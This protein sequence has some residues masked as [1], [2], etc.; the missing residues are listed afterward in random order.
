MP[1]DLAL[2]DLFRPYLLKGENTAWHAVLSVI[3]VESFETALGPEGIVIR[4]VA[5]FSGDVEITFDPLHGILRADAA[6]TEGHPRSQPGRREPWFDITDTHVEFALSAPR[7][8]GQ[9]VANGVATISGGDAAFAPT[10]AVLDAW[11]AIP[12]DAPPSDYPGTGFSLDLMLAG[13]VMR[14][15]F[16]KPAQMQPD[17]LLV[18]DTSRTD[19]VFTLPRIK[20]RLAQGSDVGANLDVSIA[21]LGAAGIDDPG[22]IAAAELITMTPPY[23]FI[24]DGRV[25]GFGFRS[26]VLDL[27][28]GFTPPAILD[29]FGFDE[30]WTGLYLPEIRLFVAPSGMED[31]AVD[32][33]VRNFLIGLGQSSGITGD[34]ELM[35]INQGSGALGLSARFFDGDGRAI[36]ITRLSDTT[37]EVLLPERSRMVIDI[38][39]GRPAYAA[40]ATFGG[41]PHNGLVHDIDLSAAAELPIGLTATDTSAPQKTAT[42][43]VTARRRPAT[44]SLP[45]PGATP[46]QPATVRTTGITLEGAPQTTPELILVRQDSGSVTISLNPAT[47]GTTWTVAG[48]A[49]PSGASVTFPLAAGQTKPIRAELSSGAVTSIVCYF[50]FDRPDVGASLGF[51]TDPDN[52]N[53]SPAVDPSGSA[54]WTPPAEA[55]LPRYRQVLKRITA[56]SLTLS[57]TASYEGDNAKDKYNYLLSRRRAEALRQ[58]LQAESANPD[59][60]QR[61]PSFTLTTDPPDIGAAAPP[62]SWVSDWKTHAAPRNL[63]WKATIG[64]FGPVSLPGTITDGEA[65]RPAGPPPPPPTIPTQDNPPATPPPPDWFRSVALKVRIVRDQFVAVEL[66][67]S[68]DFETAT[69]QRLRNGGVASGDIPQFQG[70]GS[71]NPT[72]GIVNYKILYQTDP[73]SQTD[74]VKLY[75]GADPN[76]RDGLV[77]TGQLPGQPLQAPST[78]RNVLGMTTVFTP[79][80]AATA[81]ANPADGSIGEIALSAAVLGLPIALAEAGFLNVERVVLYGGELNVTARAGQWVSTLLFDVETAISASISIGGFKILEIPREKPVAIRYKA[82]GLRMGYPPGASSRFELRPMFDSSKGYSI[83]L[84]G[85]GAVRVPDPIG[86]IIQVL[87]ARIARTNPLTFEIDLGFAVDLGVVTIERARVRLPVDPLGPPELTAFAASMNVP[88]VLEGRGYMEI[89]STPSFEIKGQIDVSLVPLKLRLAAGIGVA[90]IPASEGGPATGVIITLE[91]ELPVAI[92]LAQSGFGIYGFLGLFAMHYARDERGITSLTPALTWLKEKAQGNPINIA[93]WTPQVDHWAFGVGAILGTMEGGIIFNVKGMVILELPGPR[94]LLVVRANLLAVL[95]DLK[96]KNAEGTFLCV[97]DLDFGRGTLTIGISIE[98]KITPIVEISIPIEAYFSLGSGGDWHL[99]LG[100]F[101]GTDTLGRP[102]PG[103]IH[104]MILGVFDGSG[105]VMISGHGIPAYQGLSA[106]NGVGLAVGLEVSIVWGNTAVG[107][108]LRATAGFNAVLGFDPFYVGGI[109][110]V[111]GELHLFILSISASASLTVQIGEKADG[112]EVS[113]IDGEICGEVDLFFFSVK[114]CVDF[115]IGEPNAIVPAA[116][117]LVRAVSIVS[118]S[119]AL[120]VGTGVDKGIDSKIGDALRQDAQPAPDAEG[121][122]VVPIDSIP[123]ITMSATPIDPSLTI[124]GQVPG[125][126]PGAPA[127]GFIERGDFDYKYDVTAVELTRADGGAVVGAG[128]TP[129]TWWTLN[130]PTE[131]NL[132]A[133]LSLLNWTPNPTPKAVERSEFLEE[134]VKDRWGTVCHDA[135]PAAAVLWTFEHEPTGPSE[136]GWKVDGIAWPDPPETKRSVDPELEL[137]VHERWR[138]GDRQLDRLRGIIPAIIVGAQVACRKTRDAEPPRVA[139]AGAARVE[140]APLELAATAPTGF[141]QRLRAQRAALTAATAAS[142]GLRKADRVDVE[143]LDLG[144]T[145]RRLASGEA[146]SRAALNGIGTRVAAPRAA[147][148]QLC[149]SRLLASPMFDFG[150]PVVF[151]DKSRAEEIARRLKELGQRHGPLDDV[152]VVESGP[153]RDGKIM[154]LARRDL[155][156]LANSARALVVRFLDAEGDEL[157]R[158]AVTAADLLGVVGLPPRWG[159]AA[160][161]WAEPIGHVGGQ[162]AQLQSQGYVPYLVRF[163]KLEKLA[164]IEIGVVHEDR[165][166]VAMKREQAGRPYYVAALEFT[167][168]A[169]VEREDWDENEIKRNRGVLETFLGPD[170]GDVALLVP[171]ELYR[172]RTTVKVTARDKDGAET[173]GGTQTADFWFRTDAASPASLEPWMLCSLPARDEA[174]YFGREKVKIVFATHDVDKL[175]AAYGKELRVR[176]KA[177]SF[178]QVNEPGLQHP[179]PLVH[180]FAVAS[181]IQPLLTNVPAAVMS[182]FEAALVDGLATY[183]PCIAQD[184]DRSRHSTITIPI[185]LD[186][187][188]DYVL[189]IEAVAIGAP[190]ATVG[191][192]VL[193]RHFSTGA[194]GTFDDF[195]AT[196]QGVLTEHRS[197][198][199]GAMQGIAATPA[200]AGRDPQ[201]PELDQAMITAGLEPMPIP[202][203]PRI[204]VFWEQVGAG[205]P[206]PVAVL[207]DAPEPMRRLRPLPK[208]DSSADTPPTKRWRMLD[209]AWLDLVGAAGG[210]ATVTRTIWAPGGQRALVMLAPGS[211]GK[212]LRLALE[213]PAFT[214]PFLD[215]PGATATR[216]TVV[217]E[218]LGRAPW[219]EV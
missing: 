184:V 177:A 183:G 138:S 3:F 148:P 112:T 25:V 47:P 159:D 189:D 133:Q 199:P 143:A 219:E 64:G 206:Q 34:F 102:M 175:W 123:V 49:Q 62:G 210:D 18:P 132:V 160:G 167:G 166:D 72:D 40:Q 147:A 153:V 45:P 103:P 208:E 139:I 31:F 88:G 89:N 130:D 23:A 141:A 121:L 22:D 54:I 92:P 212:H 113:R 185:P 96:D 11:D 15:P 9:I 35:V 82:I 117:D 124:L 95:P 84:S 195:A 85:P 67:G 61:I 7:A 176:L 14:P 33:G 5:R 204:V 101:P 151:G 66:S 165:T 109:L 76:D 110:Y 90:D 122:P 58:I 105:Y 198:A 187:Y 94:L 156:Q 56:A 73:A 87:G 71:Q 8:A 188:T 118:R 128:P 48:A 120:V 201:G 6:N 70:L 77:M 142:V 119:P 10:R 190:P 57:G 17:G 180:E 63:W 169:E 174:H 170:S 202:K 217:D 83:D 191:E 192:R 97:I 161:P 193:R 197:S 146:I 154:L 214:E 24:G 26:A 111:R 108:Y 4:G 86:Q 164:R 158:H 173:D 20:L 39:G 207:V 44:Q 2:I 53:S 114:G 194:F 37:A 65:T 81:P 68:I 107:L 93:A 50:R 163:E 106:I 13:I 59:A 152:V 181:A 75:L 179:V 28:D 196:F 157:D 135:A 69:E 127:G 218:I 46:D 145:M 215:G 43:T 52:T 131:G 1:T 137:D 200:F 149:T 42:L 144:D 172:L 27:A 178:R 140:A 104:A 126:S 211:R 186:P 213:R 155:P 129:S 55:F 205:A 100:T 21:S 125:G 209:Q 216:F 168:Y 16:L 136:T 78:G 74:Q 80:L 29:Q 182:P 171:D 79:L 116:P 98:F 51:A 99:Y 19:V 134:T 12:G 162:A 36:G 30:S 60:A 150:L 203:A 115:H 41:A 91:L 32:A 38:S